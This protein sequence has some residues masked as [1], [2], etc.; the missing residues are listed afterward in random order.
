[1][2]RVKAFLVSKALLKGDSST[3]SRSLHHI[4]GERVITSIH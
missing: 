3:T 2:D 1:M 4:R